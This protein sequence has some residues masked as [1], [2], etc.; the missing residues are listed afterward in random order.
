MCGRPHTPSQAE[1]NLHSMLGMV[2]LLHLTHS[3]F[4]EAKRPYITTY[5][6]SE[7]YSRHS[8]LLGRHRAANPARHTDP[9]RRRALLKS[10]LASAD[11]LVRQFLI[12][13]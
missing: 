8:P 6:T 10:L 12:E 9:S 5:Q 4:H 7:S 3:R 2:L 1:S 13:Q 11:V